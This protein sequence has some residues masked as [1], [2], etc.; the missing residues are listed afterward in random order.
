MDFIEGFDRDQLQILSLDSM[1]K[2]GSW[3]RVVDLFVGML[4]LA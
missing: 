2:Q 3:A 1:V 4:P